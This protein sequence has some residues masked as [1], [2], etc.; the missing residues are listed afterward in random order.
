V[1]N[2]VPRLSPNNIVSDAAYL[3]HE[4][5]IRSLPV[6][7]GKRFMGVVTSQLVL[8]KLF[9]SETNVRVSSIMTPNPITV[10]PF[11]KVSNARATMVR[12]K[13]DQIPVVKEGELYGII[14]SDQIAFD[15]KPRVDRNSKGDWRESRF[16]VPVGA[17]ALMTPTTNGAG[18]SARDVF[19]TMSN[20]GTNYSVIMSDGELVGIT[21]YRDFMKILIKQR[22]E[23]LPM[24]IVG[25][26]DDPF[27]A[28]LA[29]TKFTTAIQHLRRAFPEITEARAIIKV[30]ETPSPKK[31]YR[32]HVL[33][34]SPYDRFSYTAFSY[35]IADAFDFVDGWVKKLISRR[36][37]RRRERPN[38][39]APV[40]ESRPSW[41]IA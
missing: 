36:G 9:E 10:E 13:I 30:G 6:Y 41:S 34:A 24:Y 19:L 14:T 22:T 23:S 1:M 12:R 3:M 33:I 31:R 39:K 32:V 25:L 17:Y 7:Q 11:A 35:E 2:Y 16:D 4:Y 38:R 28:E 21:T 40:I 5:R 26:P 37:A 18:D 29:R 27:E 15:L 20:K 8:G